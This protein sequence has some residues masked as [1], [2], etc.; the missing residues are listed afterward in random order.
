MGANIL[1]FKPFHGPFLVQQICLYAKFCEV[2]NMV[3]STNKIFK[4]LP[5]CDWTHQ[6]LS[7][8]KS[9]AKKGIL[10]R[11]DSYAVLLRSSFQLLLHI[12]EVSFI[13]SV[14]YTPAKIKSIK[15]ALNASSS[16]NVS[17]GDSKKQ[18]LRISPTL[19]RKSANQKTLLL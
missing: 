7:V 14:V 17:C 16:N 18:E 8:F 12:Q 1:Y 4:H 2:Q 6:D 11:Q 15:L 19:K 10:Q 5:S 13:H 3:D 9:F